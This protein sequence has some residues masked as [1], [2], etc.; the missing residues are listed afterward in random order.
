MAYYKQ[1]PII[2]EA[3]QWD[4]KQ[5]TANNFIGTDYGNQWF[6]FDGNKGNN[7]RIVIPTLEGNIIGE[8]GD[9]IIKGIEGEFYPCKSNIFEKTY[10]QVLNK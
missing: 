10:E 1:K 7:G 2:I 5:E 9:W 8:I 3:V 6:F 4:G